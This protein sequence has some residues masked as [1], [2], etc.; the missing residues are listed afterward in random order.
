MLGREEEGA[1]K[2][3]EGHKS[4]WGMEWGSG[5]GR[6]LSRSERGKEF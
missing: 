2:E 3:A 1:R 4:G 6:H 5:K